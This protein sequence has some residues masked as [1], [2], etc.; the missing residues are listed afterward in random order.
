[1]NN[2]I[3]VTDESLIELDISKEEYRYQNLLKKQI[4]AINSNAE[5]I[6]RIANKLYESVTKYHSYL[7]KRCAK[8]IELEK[9]SKKYHK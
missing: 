1:M 3:P 4:K 2:M 6:C 5:E 7:E 9:Q 8:F